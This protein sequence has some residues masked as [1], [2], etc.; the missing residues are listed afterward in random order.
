MVGEVVVAAPDREQSAVGS[1]LTHGRPLRAHPFSPPVE[2]VTAYS[3]EGTPADCILLALR[4]LVEGVDLVVSGINP[5]LNLGYDALISGTIGA[6]LHGYFHG[7]P[8]M[9]LSVEGGEAT[10]FHTAARFATIVTHKIA[11]KALPDRILLNINLPNLP[12]EE[13][14]GVEVTRL[15]GWWGFLDEIEEWQHGDVTVYRFK[16][17]QLK[18]NEEGTDTQAL[19]DGRISITPLQGDLTSPSQI[20]LLQ[21]LSPHLLQ[22]L[23]SGRA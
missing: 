22:G 20:P 10:S 5:G 14:K 23:Q 18:R 17:G 13:I 12:V 16:R 19:L 2:E 6:A 9:A 11:A 4:K 15:A 21:R 7:L 8:S 3:I 1:S